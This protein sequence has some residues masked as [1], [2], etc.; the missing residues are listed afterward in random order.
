MQAELIEVMHQQVRAIH[1]ALTGDDVPATTGANDD[2]ATA[3]DSEEEITRR[4]TELAAL[5][6]AMPSVAERV[7]PFA[8][9]PAVDVMA[10]DRSVMIEIAVCGV[11][12]ADVTVE[13]VDGALVVRGV[14][15]FDEPVTGRLFHAEI[16]RGPFLRVIPLPFPIAREPRIELAQGLLRIHL[17]AV[18]LQHDGNGS[19]DGAVDQSKTGTPEESKK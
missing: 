8:F 1:R 10:G 13:R 15:R 14:R 17:D 6:R 12:R 19:R 2:A 5:V 11:R 18:A 3:D 4:F 16:P 7:P 9:T